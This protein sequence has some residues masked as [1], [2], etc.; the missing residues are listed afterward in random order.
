[1]ASG[2]KKRPLKRKNPENAARSVFVS[3]SKHSKKTSSLMYW[4]IE[5]FRDASHEGAQLGLSVFSHGQS[6]IPPT[7]RD[8]I[9]KY[10]LPKWD[11]VRK[12]WENCLKPQSLDGSMEDEGEDVDRMQLDS[13]PQDDQQ[14]DQRS[15][16][17]IDLAGSDD[18]DDQLPPPAPSTLNHADG[19]G[20]DDALD[21]ATQVRTHQSI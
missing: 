11:D 13:Q 4:C 6:G 2:P 17:R 15:P 9:G 10:Q 14:I 21:L 19:N 8:D 16:P 3:K 12:A 20:S 7:W 5:C 18:V 1:M